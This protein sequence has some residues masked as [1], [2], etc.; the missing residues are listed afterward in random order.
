MI[1]VCVAGCTG[2]TGAA[3]TKAV[4]QSKDL[5]LVSSI[6][7]KSAGQ[8]AGEALGIGEAGII[9]VSTLEQGLA[10]RPD[11]VVDYIGAEGVKQRVLAA[12]DK[13]ARVVVGSSGLSGDDYAEIENAA[14]QKNLGVAAAGNFSVTAA[15]AKKCAMLAAEHVPSWEIIDYAQADK[16]DA[17][18]GTARELAESL[19]KVRQ[20]AVAIPV[21]ETLGMAEARGATVAGAQVHSLR[22]PGF[23]FS[24]ETVFGMAGERLSIRHDAGSSAD[25]YV[26]GT[27][28]AVRKVMSVTG[29]VRGMDKLLFG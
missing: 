12:L 4:L 7:R 15:L 20:N 14:L 8:D 17:P 26:S 27:L 11:V 3:V 16:P 10:A 6:A 25:P 9:V 5:R 2:W 21:S 19:S 13:G 24:F 23:N 28:L 29:L 22:L 18:S 1:K